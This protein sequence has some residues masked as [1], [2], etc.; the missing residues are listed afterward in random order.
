MTERELKIYRAILEALRAVPGPYLL[1]EPILAA[2][3]RHLVVPPPEPW[4][5]VAALKAARNEGCVLTVAGVASQKY[6]L[7]DQG[8]AWLIANS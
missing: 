6:Q 2:D 1:P 7:T 4:E 8:R 5:F 3:V